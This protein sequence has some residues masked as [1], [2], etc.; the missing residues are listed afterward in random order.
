[1][2]RTAPRHRSTAQV[3]TRPTP[4]QPLRD[5]GS[6]PVMLLLFVVTPAGILTALTMGAI[7]LVIKATKQELD[8]FQWFMTSFVVLALWAGVAFFVFGAL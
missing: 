7:Y 1:M 2:D 8:G 6:F 3:E 4:G 5:V